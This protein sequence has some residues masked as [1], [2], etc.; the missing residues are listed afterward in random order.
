M[1][2]LLRHLFIVRALHDDANNLTSNIACRSIRKCFCLSK[3][4]QNLFETTEMFEFVN[5]DEKLYELNPSIEFCFKF[6]MINEGG[7]GGACEFQFF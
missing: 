7:R 1:I 2:E 6:G 3:T 4:C 5:D